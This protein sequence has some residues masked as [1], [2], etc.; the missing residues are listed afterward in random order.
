MSG[1][2]KKLMSAFSGVAGPVEA[3]AVDFD[4]TSDYL[5]KFFGNGAFGSGSKTVTFSAWFY[6][7]GNTS[8][9]IFQCPT[10]LISCN[11]PA[12]NR[13]SMSGFSSSYATILGYQTN[14]ALAKDTWNHVLISFDLSNSSNRHVYIND[15]LV[16]GTYTT[17]SNTAIGFDQAGT[18]TVS[19]AS[20]PFLGRLAG[21]YLDYTYRDLSVEANRRLFITAK[22]TPAS[23]QASLSPILYLP[24]DDPA[25]AGSNKG[26]GGDFT[27]NGI[28]ARSGRGPNQYNAAASVFDGSTDKLTTVALSGVSDGK[29]ATFSCT[30][31][32]DTFDDDPFISF[33]SG[34]TQRFVA[35]ISDAGSYGYLT[36]IGLNADLTDVVRLSSTAVKF[37]KNKTHSLQFSFDMTDPSKRHV[38]VDGV[39]ITGLTWASYS[40]DNIDF[41]VTTVGV[42]V[43]GGIGN[44]YVDGSVGDVYFDTSYVDLSTANPFYDADTGKPEFLGV[45]GE[46]PTGSAP[47][48]YLPMRPD[49]AGDNRGTGGD[50]TVSSGP[51]LGERGASEFWAES[52]YS[53][54]GANYLSNPTFSGGGS[55]VSQV[56]FAMAYKVSGT[57]A[58]LL[59]VTGNA[60]SSSMYIK[61]IHNTGY[62]IS[63]RDVNG[64]DVIEATATT[65]LTTGTWHTLLMSFDITNPAKRHVYVDGVDAG[66]V[67]GHYVTSR[68]L[69]IGTGTTINL[70]GDGAGTSALGSLGFVYVSDTYIDFS[71]E[72]NRLKFFDSMGYPVD[73]GA[74]GSLPTESSPLVYMNKDFILGT[75]SGTGG[76]FT[77]VGSPTDGGHVKG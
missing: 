23:G 40:N 54:A 18:A 47:L 16:G 44:R 8:Q 56:T 27:L 29:Q 3:Q 68:R 46:L 57:N 48:I 31:K 33:E 65:A 13:L 9:T 14:A 59:K 4:G 32:L 35:R 41:T 72:A 26:T 66:F 61:P 73:I 10:F 11:Q 20:A 19:S 43:D 75:N 5:T 42:G 38:V 36:L 34:G 69:E 58:T 70:L 62:R 76:D 52:G 51:F 71:Q 25:D 77:I 37:Y 30:F 60:S 6:W 2:S 21:V 64:G 53:I 1:I 17:Y 74:D 67:Y 49:N 12:G 7:S 22:G 24:M 63:F 45:F 55:S 39:E 28:V 50:F 15:V